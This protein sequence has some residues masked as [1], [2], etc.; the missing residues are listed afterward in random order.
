MAIATAYRAINMNAIH[1]W[2]SADLTV[3][4][5]T[6]LQETGFTGQVQNY[7]GVNFSGSIDVGITGGTLTG[8]NYILNGVTQYNVTGLNHS[9]VAVYNY[10]YADDIQ[11]MVQYLFGGND[12]LNGS[13]YA[14]LIRGHNGNDTINGNGGADRIF[15]D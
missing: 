9:A 3:A 6:H 13:A 8:T 5:S 15:G 1:N 2:E 14:D 7:F 11:G 10:W 12:T 4:S